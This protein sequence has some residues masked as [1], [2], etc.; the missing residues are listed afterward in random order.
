MDRH[1]SPYIAFAGYTYISSGDLAAVAGAAKKAVDSGDTAPIFT[2]FM[3]LTHGA[4]L[5]G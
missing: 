1:P 5:P 2:G 3:D 4:F